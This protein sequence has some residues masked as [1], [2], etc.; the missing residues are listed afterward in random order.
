MARYKS[1]KLGNY[2]RLWYDRHQPWEREIALYDRCNADI[3]VDTPSACL[4][5][6]AWR[7]VIE[8]LSWN[9]VQWHRLEQDETRQVR[10]LRITSVTSR[11]TPYE[12]HMFHDALELTTQLETCLL[13]A[14]DYVV[15]RNQPNAR[16]AVE[17]LEPQGHDSFFRWGFFN[18]MREK[19]EHYSNYVFEDLAWDMLQDEPALMEKFLQWKS[20]RPGLLT[21]QKAV[22]NF[23]FANG[24]RCAEPG[25]M[26]YPVFGLV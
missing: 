16:Y 11:A 15:P 5:P 4:V 12:G 2:Q 25:W 8:R 7:E 19:K 17:T 3:E 18:S 24:Q 10:A 9:Q 26:R 20:H 1:S 22:L 23:I 14:G 6:Q 21:Y 13:R